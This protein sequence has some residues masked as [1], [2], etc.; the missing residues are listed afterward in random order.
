MKP[1]MVILKS[2][3]KFSAQNISHLVKCKSMTANKCFLGR[4]LF[5]FLLFLFVCVC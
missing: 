4:T 5:F 1:N 2:G 3:N